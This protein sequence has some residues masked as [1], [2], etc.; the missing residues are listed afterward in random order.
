[1]EP[2]SIND[3]ILSH[4]QEEVLKY[5]TVDCDYT[6]DRMNNLSLH[7]S[8]LEEKSN[9]FMWY[10]EDETYTLNDAEITISEN[11]FTGEAS[12]GN[13][14]GRKLVDYINSKKEVISLLEPTKPY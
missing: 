11:K 8:A 1:M 3:Y 10:L 7:K 12:T 2:E 14:Q 9:K 4:S 5:K 13:S 6:P